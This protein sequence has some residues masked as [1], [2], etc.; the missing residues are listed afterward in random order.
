MI[1]PHETESG[2]VI[3]IDQKK[4][5]DSLLSDLTKAAQ[6]VRGWKDKKDENPLDH[7]REDARHA[8][9]NIIVST[10]AGI[11]VIFAV[12][13]SIAALYSDD[14]HM[15]SFLSVVQTVG[16]I[17]TPVVTFIMG[18]YYSNGSKAS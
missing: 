8:L 5:L 14:E 13:G 9:G 18:Y 17:L 4:D 11:I 16:S 10:F 7:K 15:K 1:M 12:T 2:N 6:E 3:P